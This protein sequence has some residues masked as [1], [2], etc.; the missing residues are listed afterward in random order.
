MMA[1]EEELEPIEVEVVVNQLVQQ[2]EVKG[3]GRSLN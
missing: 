2:V 3:K 1:L